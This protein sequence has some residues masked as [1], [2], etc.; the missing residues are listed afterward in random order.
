MNDATSHPFLFFISV[1]GAAEKSPKK[2]ENI[3]KPILEAKI[4]L[5]HYFTK[6]KQKQK[7]KIGELR[8]TVDATLVQ[9]VSQCT[10]FFCVFYYQKKYEKYV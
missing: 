4:A 8:S 3:E 10:V 2:N 7:Q 1:R 9:S 5:V 6:Q